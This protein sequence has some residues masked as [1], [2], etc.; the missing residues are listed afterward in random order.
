MPYE[1]VKV[2]FAPSPT[3]LLHIGSAH[4]ALFN[5][6]F[7]KKHKG[8]F[9]LRIEDT[10]RERS[11]EEYLENIISNLKWLGL[12]WDEFYKQ[13]E[14]E[15]IYREYLE[16][17]LA[18][19][20]AY[21]CFC[22]KE[23]L[24]SERQAMLSQGLAPKY[25]G[26]CRSLTKE[27]AE[28]RRA[29]GENCVIRLKASG[30]EISFKDMIRDT[31]KF[32]VS[33][34][35][36]FVIAKSLAEP[37]YNFAVV[38]DDALMKI[39]HVIRGEDHIS[40]TPKQILIAVAL[41]FEIPSFAHLPIIL[42]PDRSKMS[43]RFLDTAL[44]DY[45]EDGYLREA[46]INFL[47]FMGWHPKEDK[48]VM[49][50][51]E[52]IEEFDLNRVQKSGAVFNAEKLNWLNGQYLSRLSSDEFKKRAAEFL[53][54]N[55]ELT[56]AIIDSVKERLKTL[57]DLKANVKFYFEEPDYKTD[58]LR[59][60]DVDYDKIKSGLE[61]AKS[62]LTRTKDEDFKEEELNKR[63]MKLID[64]RDRGEV[65]WP[66]RVAL[67]GE[68]FSPG[69]FEIMPILGKTKTLQR[70]DAALQKLGQ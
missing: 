56:E 61:F 1:D 26:R 52:I 62:I 55:W 63:I 39:T 9:V 19:D 11:K 7:A 41:G 24:E 60:K 36:D 53:P 25:S 38:V 14:R 2:R 23:E 50:L 20:K 51:E 46:L 13:S 64:G 33:L 57:G 4:T 40:N 6:L 3:G 70:I 47:A 15:A 8:K 32:D 67:T 31:I 42:N 59:W 69:P 48:E 45:R 29:G 58:L 54:E 37:L 22:T 10:D 21:Y 49:T 35:G 5:Y 65:L 28:G 18:E 12:D 27:E 66:L 16:K 34:I 17:L 30:G 43:K 68:R 44:D